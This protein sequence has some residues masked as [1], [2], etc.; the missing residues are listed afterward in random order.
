MEEIA[1]IK[2]NDQWKGLWQEF[3][4][5][6]GRGA[7]EALLTPAALKPHV[8]NASR[9]MHGT[10][11]LVNNPKLQERDVSLV[12]TIQGST[13]EEYLDKYAKFVAVLQKGEVELKIPALSKE[14]RL[15]YESCTKF[16][17]Y[18]LRYG[19]FSLRFREPEPKS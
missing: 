5:R 2:V 13:Q 11:V 15:I 4:A 18:G 7:Y 6:L 8:E 12:I 10:Q 1:Y 14:F 17:N 9:L 16:G 3:N 19:K